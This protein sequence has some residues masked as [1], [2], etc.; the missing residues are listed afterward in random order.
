MNHPFCALPQVPML[1]E[2]VS[3]YLTQSY[4]LDTLGGH[5]FAKKDARRGVT[6]DLLTSHVWM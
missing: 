4:I 6:Y 5:G 1:S 2:A 3:N